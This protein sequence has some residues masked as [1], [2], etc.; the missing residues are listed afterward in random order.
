MS[1]TTGDVDGVMPPSAPRAASTTASGLHDI[2]QYE[3]SGRVRVRSTAAAGGAHRRLDE[4]QKQTRDAE[5]QVTQKPRVLSVHV[6][7]SLVRGLRM[8]EWIVTAGR[9]PYCYTR[10]LDAPAREWL[11]RCCSRENPGQC[12]H[13]A[14]SLPNRTSIIKNLGSRITISYNSNATTPLRTS[15]RA[16]KRPE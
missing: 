10:V 6:V 2:R 4:A 3:A 9:M 14:R 11:M 13:T 12:M 7:D 15:R 1:P 8:Y 16:T 5:A